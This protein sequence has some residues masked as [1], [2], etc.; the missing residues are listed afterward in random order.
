MKY[1]YLSLL[2]LLSF[3]LITCQSKT[4][5]VAAGYDFFPLETGRF[6]IY[7]VTEQ[8]YSLGAAPI[9]RTYQIRE[10]LT[11]SLGAATY[12]LERSRRS[13]ENQAWQ[14]DSISS[15]RLSHDQL[16]RTDNNL[17][18][19]KLIFPV[20]DQ[21]LWNG[22]AFNTLGADDYQFRNMRQPFS[23]LNQTFPETVTILQQNDSTL[24]NQDKRVE[25]YARTVGMIYRERIQLQFCSSTPSCVGSGQIDFGIRQFVRL[26]SYGKP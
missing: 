25:V 14:P 8:Q 21:S 22:N 17:D 6:W 10:E 12:R 16:I 4:E 20:D 13:T 19:V 24:V 26:R 1:S 11:T 5:P 23:V 2:V 15:V 18:Y 7:D 3:C 9:N